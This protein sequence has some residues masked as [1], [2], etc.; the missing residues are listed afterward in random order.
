VTLPM[1]GS[2]GPSGPSGAPAS[3]TDGG[4]LRETSPS[5][6]AAAGRPPWDEMPR[7]LALA[8]TREGPPAPPPG[9]EPRR[10]RRHS[11]R[12]DAARGRIA[13]AGALA[14]LAAGRSLTAPP[15]AHLQ[16]PFDILTPQAAR[17]AHDARGGV[18]GIPALHPEATLTES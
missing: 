7:S 17:L 6:A 15:P 1:P 12:R 16:R 9:T 10:G 18:G 13:A 5:P 4:D 2:A 11:P 3:G 14:L 8:P